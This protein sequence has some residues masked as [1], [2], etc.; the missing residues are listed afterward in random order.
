VLRGES[1]SSASGGKDA[2]AAYVA[3]IADVNYAP[4]RQ[5]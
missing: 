3:G 4:K 5:E 2:H 1:I